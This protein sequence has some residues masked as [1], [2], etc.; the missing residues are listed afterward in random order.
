M[1]PGTRL[2]QFDAT[3]GL[4]RG[5]AKIVE[6]VWYLVKCAFFLSALPW[7]SRFKCGLLRWFG[8]KV[9]KG[10]NI[11]PRVNIHFPW[12]LELGDWCW[13]GEEVF[14]LNFEQVKIGAHACV[15]QRAFLC[16]GNHDYKDPSFAFRNQPISIGQGA[17]VGASVFVAPG[18]HV[19]DFAVIAAGSVVTR[20]MPE[21]M[22]CSGNPCTPQRQRW[23]T[24]SA[25]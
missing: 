25:Y 2:D 21:R 9:G 6:A 18:V 10:V 24:A 16:G 11:K 12:K 13:L 4:V 8:A 22:V 19:G 3:R 7:P 15:S 5:R 1:I 20:D 14:I 17:W 23:N